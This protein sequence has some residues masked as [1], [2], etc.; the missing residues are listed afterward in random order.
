MRTTYSLVM[1]YELHQQKQINNTHTH[2]HTDIIQR[3]HENEWQIIHFIID[4]LASKCQHRNTKM[5]VLYRYKC[6]VVYFLE[7]LLSILLSTAHG[8]VSPVCMVPP[9]MLLYSQTHSYL[10]LLCHEMFFVFIA[11]HF[12]FNL[13]TFFSALRF[14]F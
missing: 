2:T 7:L 9:Y 12:I 10:L 1:L 11:C 4:R 8:R 3:L 14:L 6:V 13:I 5:C